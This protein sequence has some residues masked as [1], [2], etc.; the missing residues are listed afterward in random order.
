MIKDS[1]YKA[2]LSDLKL[3][4]RQSQIKAAVRVNSE[5][6][7]LYWSIGADI[8]A[9]Q[10][11]SVWGSGVIPQLSAD[12]RAEFPDMQGL[13]YRNL[14]LYRQF[15]IAYPQV[16]DYLPQFFQIHLSIGRS[17]ST[18]L[19]GTNNQDITIWQSPIAKSENN[20]PSIWQKLSAKLQNVD[21]E[22]VAIWHSLSAKFKQYDIPCFLPTN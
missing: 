14:R 8:V 15:Y 5:M 9:K 7:A 4:V 17:L 1:D 3:R 21:N 12:L 2:W 19:Q 18:Q 10:A 22:N 11:E 16:K 20:L 13:S 6:I